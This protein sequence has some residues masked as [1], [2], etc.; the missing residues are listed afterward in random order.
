MRPAWA[1]VVLTTLVC[2]ALPA[3]AG[4]T[5]VLVMSR[6]GRVHATNDRFMPAADDLAPVASGRDRPRAQR[7]RAR[8]AAAVTRSALRALRD[9]GQVDQPTYDAAA[10]TYAHALKLLGKVKGFRKVQMSAVVR[11]LDSMAAGG[12][13]TPARLPALMETL[14][15]NVE[16]WSD[17]PL[18]ATGQRV[19]FAGS[20]IVWQHYANE[21]IQI[22]WLAT[23]GKANALFKDKLHD[24]EFRA[25]LDE[26]LS[27][28][29]QRAGGIAFEYL[30]PFDGGRPPWVSGLA[31]ATAATA[32]SRGAIR[33]EDPDYFVAAR[34]SLGIFKTP[35]P[36]GI[37]EPQAHGTHYLQYSFA[38][39]LHILNGFVQSLNG[40]H[41]FAVYANDDE[42]RALF[43]AGETELRAELPAFDTGGWSRYSPGRDSP[44]SYHELLAGFLHKLCIR[45]RH[46]GEDGEI[47]C[48]ASDRFTA[49]LTTPP[50]LSLATPAHARKR[51]LTSL[52]LG[53]DK[54][55][56]A[57]ITFK[58]GKSVRRVALSLS[59]GRHRIAW[60]PSKPGAYAV[61]VS[62][63]DPA[64]NRGSIDG[65]AA[66][67]P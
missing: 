27:L 40:L 45:M 24:S 22:Q 31:E 57:T 3:S 1:T 17:G 32:L 4:A 50:V 7:P 12:R 61:H 67:R 60:R 34:S 10:S 20:R 8:A 18:L 66:V 9:S 47:Y 62:A 38:P 29:G 19:S 63:V 2:L 36:E 28:A 39:G 6:D 64:G 15:R 25:A 37:A 43:Q 13:L 55:V 5:R 49:D 30:F 59:S 44:L 52:S 58:R 21:G 53:V 54:P 51:R 56:R 14:E 23:W 48:Q 65:T 33:L 16:W 46:A 11:D 35:P 42:G 41:D 26:A